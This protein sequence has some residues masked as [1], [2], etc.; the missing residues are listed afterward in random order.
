MENQTH[1]SRAD[2]AMARRQMVERYQ[3]S[4]KSQREFC[5]GEGVSLST[6]Q[7]WIRRTSG[8]AEP[9]SMELREV[10]WPAGS[11]LTPVSAW[12]LELV[13]PRGWTLRH[14]EA[15]GAAELARL[16]KSLKC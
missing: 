8:G 16:L 4:G 2:R 1:K 7:W 6:L 3:R 9:A 13:S 14:R 15:P 11:T 10:E 5:E 12:G